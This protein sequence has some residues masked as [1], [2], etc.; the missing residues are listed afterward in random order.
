MISLNTNTTSWMFNVTSA[1]WFRVLFRCLLVVVV[2]A[3][4]QDLPSPVVDLA[5][6]WSSSYPSSYHQS[7]I[8]PHWRGLAYHLR[9]SWA[10]IFQALVVR[11]VST[12]IL[13]PWVSTIQGR[14][15]ITT[16]VMLLGLAAFSNQSNQCW[17]KFLNQAIGLRVITE[18][19]VR[20][21]QT[22][23]SVIAFMMVR[24]DL[25]SKTQTT[26]VQVAFRNRASSQS[27]LT[28][29]DQSY[30]IGSIW[31]KPRR[32]PAVLNTAE[33]WLRWSRT[34]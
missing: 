6:F 7:T 32:R 26:V 14:L 8:D 9:L 19:D 17:I 15:L 33:R 22:R 29:V 4:H 20:A 13:S 2:L 23:L 30:G 5:A 21:T 27:G 11:S 28:L 25:P 1:F 16:P 24:G 12:C 3:S 31:Q 10:A 18:C 34:C